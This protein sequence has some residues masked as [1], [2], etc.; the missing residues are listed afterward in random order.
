M[1]SFFRRNLFPLM[2]MVLPATLAVDTSSG[3]SSPVDLTPSS[4]SIATLMLCCLFGFQKI[5]ILD[6]GPYLGNW[7]KTRNFTI[8]LK[9]DC[10]ISEICL[11]FQFQDELKSSLIRKNSKY[12]AI[13]LLV[14]TQEQ[15]VKV[16]LVIQGAVPQPSHYT[17][18]QHVWEANSLM[19]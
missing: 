19:S 12:C 10:C 16:P 14:M 2:K 9:I 18:T 13:I 11:L 4:V 8:P 5:G 3:S 7:L 15:K 17:K 6:P 1:A